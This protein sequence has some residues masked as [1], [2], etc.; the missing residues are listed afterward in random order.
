MKRIDSGYK[1]IEVLSG[2]RGS[3]DT[4]VNVA[5]VEFRFGAVVLIG[6]ICVQSQ[7]TCSTTVSLETYPIILS[8]PTS[9]HRRWTLPSCSK[10][11]YKRCVRYFLLKMDHWIMQF[12]SH[13]LKRTRVSFSS[14]QKQNQTNQDS[15]TNVFPRQHNAFAWSFDWFLGLPMY[16]VI[17]QVESLP[18]LSS[19]TTLNWKTESR[20]ISLRFC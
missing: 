17:G 14:N 13:W 3:A 4:V 7:S 15:V 16:S 6:K 10:C 18:G 2:R 5:T 19:I 12:N 20:F 9:P 8:W 1:L 11:N